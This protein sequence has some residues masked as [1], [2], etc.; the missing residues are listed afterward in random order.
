[1]SDFSR[2]NFLG[3]AA[4]AASVAGAEAA[5]QAAEHGA[6]N[7]GDDGDELEPIPTF[8]YPMET[9]KGRRTEGGYSREATIKQLPISEGLAGVSMRLK[10]GGVRELHWHAKAAEWAFVIKGNVRTTVISPDGT[11][12]T[13]DF[14]PGDVWYFPRG[15]GH[16]LQG[17]GPDEAH[18]ILIFDDGA[19]SEFGTF[20]ASDWLAVTPPEV[21]SKNFGVPKS[22][23]D[24]FVK[25]ETFIPQG[26]IPPEKQ[27]APLMGF[28]R[29][30]PLTHKY[31]L[32][33]QEPRRFNGGQERKV[34]SKEFPMSEDITGVLLE[35]EPGALREL[36]WHPN[37][38]E[39][40]YWIE[41]TGRVG[42]FGSHGRSRIESF[43]VGDAG[44]IP[45]GYG[46]YIE[47]TGTTPLK[48]LIGFNSGEYQAIDASAWF[49]SN[50]TD[51]L[52]ATFGV[53]PSAFESFP[54]HKVFIAPKE[55]PRE[56]EGAAHKG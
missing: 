42:I 32:M 14:A 22:T 40:Q 23:V 46:H 53:P 9:E 34:S 27:Y 10:P 36:H 55:G 47:N 43:G 24:K 44:Y 7:D 16:A 19:F 38:D 31:P 21:V 39:W 15:H 52:S 6:N 2:R 50:P 13:N 8:R 1:M 25:T 11:S 35:L 48:V 30:S 56:A 33:S 41:G 5:A 29:T 54:R 49:A 18:F 17:M 4:I 3:R 28:Q 51:I 45:R 26:A 37:A 12:E 20:S